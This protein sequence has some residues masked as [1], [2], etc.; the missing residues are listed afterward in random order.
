MTTVKE[1]L[2][3]I[4]KDEHLQDGVFQVLQ[5]MKAARRMAEET[6]READLIFLGNRV[7]FDA[8]TRGMQYG[9]IIKVNKKTVKVKSDKGLIW[10]VSRS[11]VQKI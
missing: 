3:L 9:E 8:R 1:I 11:L 6:F 10:N 5:G 2:E 7:K 4:G